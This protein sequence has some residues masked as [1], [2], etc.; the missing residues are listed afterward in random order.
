MLFAQLPIYGVKPEKPVDKR[1]KEQSVFIIENIKFTRLD[2]AHW[3]FLNMDTVFQKKY[4]YDSNGMAIYSEGYVMDVDYLKHVR[5]Y[6]K[7]D[8][9]FRQI[10]IIEIDDDS[11]WIDTY[12]LNYNDVNNTVRIDLFFRDHFADKDE[13]NEWQIIK[14]DKKGNL[15]FSKT[16][17]A[18]DTVSYKPEYK[19]TLSDKYFKALDL[20]YDRG[21]V[22][23]KS[24][25]Y[26]LDKKGRM[27]E[28]LGYVHQSNYIYDKNGNILQFR[29]NIDDEDKKENYMVI[30][31]YNTKGQLLTVSIKDNTGL[32][33]VMEKYFYREDGLL[34]Y[35]NYYK[36][37]GEFFYGFKYE[38]TLR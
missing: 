9:K 33:T 21:E 22:I 11:T 3:N 1:I 6:Y 37:N 20:I 36:R 32:L 28:Y 34:E 14:L 18:R 4:F 12:K 15:I 5:N 19:D 26:K 10:E 23:D 16:Y 31:V 38:Y 25:Y 27:I 13:L 7:Y 29:V 35:M 2:T 17:L 24:Y 30:Y 8:N